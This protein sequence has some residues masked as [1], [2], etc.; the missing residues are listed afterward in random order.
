MSAAPEPLFS[1]EVDEEFLSAGSL[2]SPA[3]HTGSPP[4][5]AVTDT[6]WIRKAHL[7]FG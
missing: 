6:D 5:P 2:T 1:A 7:L 3:A 4:P